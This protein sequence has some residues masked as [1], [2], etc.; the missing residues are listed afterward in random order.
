MLTLDSDIEHGD[1]PKLRLN[2]L[3]KV[4]FGDRKFEQDPIV[5]EE[6][7]SYHPL[8]GDEKQFLNM[9]NFN[10]RG[11]PNTIVTSMSC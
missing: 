9:T 7:E 5:T 6:I 1:V 4:M 3:D 8:P 10:R 2:R 11:I